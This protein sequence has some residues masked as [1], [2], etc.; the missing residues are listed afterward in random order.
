[1]PTWSFGQWIKAAIVI[2]ACI[3]VLYV[4]LGFMGIS[5]PPFIITIFW[6]LVA[7]AVG[8]VAINFLIGMWKQGP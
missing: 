6:I 8:L 1:M 2:A 7:A 3:A 5:I 4:I